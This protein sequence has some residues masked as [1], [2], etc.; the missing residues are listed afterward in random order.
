MGVIQYLIITSMVSVRN[1]LLP[2]RSWKSQIKIFDSFESNEHTIGIF[3]DLKRAF[4][5]VNHSILL[6]KLQFYA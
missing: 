1:R 4:D 3:I 2:W 6:D 5:T